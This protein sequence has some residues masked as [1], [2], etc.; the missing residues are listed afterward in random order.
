MEKMSE[1]ADNGVLLYFLETPDFPLLEPEISSDDLLDSLFYVNNL[2]TLLGPF[3]EM[4][5]VGIS[6]ARKLDDLAITLWLIRN[7]QYRSAS[8]NLF[9]LIE[10]EHKKA[11]NA[12][13]GIVK[14]KTSL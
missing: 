11:A 10:S 3:F 6:M 14:K 4:K 2:E 7:K 12:Y 1:Y 9:A 13:E 8:R 5:D